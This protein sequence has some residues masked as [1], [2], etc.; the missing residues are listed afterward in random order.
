M[1]FNCDEK[2]IL[3]HSCAKL[4]WL[5][6]KDDDGRAFNGE[7]RDDNPEI[8]EEEQVE[9][10]LHAISGTQGPRTMR[11]RGDLGCCKIMLLVDSGNTHNLISP[12]IARRVGITPVP[13][14]KIRVVVVNGK[15]LL[16]GGVCKGVTIR[17]GG[18]SFTIDFYVL[19]IEG[20]ES[21][22]GACWL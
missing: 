16:S 9:I 2:F 18:Y 11:V 20:C 17:L 10:S 1:N 14:K 7:N 15:T 6:L 22:L 4:F 21:V 12:A 13:G 8:Q 5:E 19:E 3:G